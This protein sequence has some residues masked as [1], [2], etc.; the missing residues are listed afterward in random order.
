MLSAL[1]SVNACVMYVLGVPQIS[2]VTL[3]SEGWSAGIV[4]L[5]LCDACVDA[6]LHPAGGMG[7]R[8]HRWPSGDVRT[9]MH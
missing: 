6:V 4:F 5:S 1:D 9:Q 2:M 8:G 7:S 3:D